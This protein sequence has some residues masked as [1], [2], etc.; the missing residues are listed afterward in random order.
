M[1]PVEVACEMGASTGH[2]VGSVLEE[3]RGHEETP[4]GEVELKLHGFWGQQD[5]YMM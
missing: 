4:G 1:G 3:V 5:W 2:L